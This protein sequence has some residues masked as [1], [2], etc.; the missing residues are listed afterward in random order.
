MKWLVPAVVICFLELWPGPGSCADISGRNIK[1]RV[2]ATSVPVHSG[3]G[4]SYRQVGSVGKGQVFKALDRSPD[5][6]WYLIRLTRGTA[7][8]VLSELVW[9]FEIVDSD[10]VSDTRGW[11]YK[12]I[13]APSLLQD[14]AV[15]L[16]LGGGVLG[17]D[18]TFFT[19]LGFMPNRHWLME[20]MAGQS[21]SHLGGVLIYGAELLVT[22]APWET[23]VPFAAVG[24]G[25]ATTLPN[26]QAELFTWD[27]RPLLSTG[28]GFLLSLR[29][30]LIFRLDA[31]EFFAMSSHDVWEDLSITCSLMLLF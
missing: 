2:M 31:R 10:F 27:T 29:G 28:G 18:G 15:S 22:I 12:Y 14:G 16:C 30:G 13:L 25:A 26:S 20:L 3:P 17:S 11:L 5:G 21:M 19:R 23:L 7:G 1:L 4:G 9:P 24:A 8:W 6:D